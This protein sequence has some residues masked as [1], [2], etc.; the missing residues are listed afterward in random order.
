[1]TTLS[2]R[3]NDGMEYKAPAGLTEGER[4]VRIEEIVG[5]MDQRLFG[6]GQP[7]EL[8]NIK[9]RIRSLEEYKW[10]LAGALSLAIVLVESLVH[11]HSS[12]P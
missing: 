5:R 7:G 4:L 12:K 8:S 9:H 11:W 10:K 3:E 1:M 6:N 2:L